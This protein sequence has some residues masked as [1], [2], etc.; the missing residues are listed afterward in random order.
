[1]LP[2]HSVGNAFWAATT[3]SE[4][5]LLICLFRRRFQSTHRLFLTYVTIA[6]LQSAFAVTIYL[7]TDF[8]SPFTRNI[9]WSSQAFVL[10]ARSAA[11]FEMAHRILARYLGI[12]SLALRTLGIVVV[13]VLC[14]SAL[15]SDKNWS[16][17]ILN[18]D[19]SMELAIAA[20]IVTLLLFARYYALPIHPVD[21]ALSIG[22]CLYS[23][24]YVIND[25][26]LE[27]WLMAYSE[28]WNF[29]SILS[30]LASILIW[31]QAVWVYRPQE[32]K[33]AGNA[34]APGLYERISPELNLRLRLLNEQLMQL[35]RSENQ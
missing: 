13:L 32:V 23:S 33:P 15:F 1:M 17:F 20:F 22:F 21:R 16:V 8:N 2:Y 28:L 18:M 3:A 34:V 30:F 7:N 12:W 11:V 10:I 24:F 25:S 9:I 29:L 6:I 27:K 14:Y 19:R 4:L 26:L 35:L 31:V 5:V